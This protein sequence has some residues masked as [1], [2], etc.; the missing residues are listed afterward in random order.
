M[1]G[2]LRCDFRIDRKFFKPK[3]QSSRRVTHHLEWADD[4]RL[5]LRRVEGVRNRNAPLEMDKKAV[6]DKIVRIAEMEVG[7]I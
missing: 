7:P 4:S 5:S 3:E 6:C 2:I 1:S